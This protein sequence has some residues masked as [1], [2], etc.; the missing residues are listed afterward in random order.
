MSFYSPKD[1][2]PEFYEKQKNQNFVKTPKEM[3]F[4]IVGSGPA[5]FYMAKMLLTTIKNCRV[6]IFDRNPHPYGLIRTGVAPDHQAMKKI[7]KDFKQVFEH[8]ADRTAFFGNVWVGDVKEGQEDYEY[9][10]QHEHSISVHQL[11]TKYSGVILAH[12]ALKDR[13]LG[14]PKEES[15]GILPSRRVVNWYNDSLDNDLDIQNEF[16]LT[17]IRDLAVI[18]NGN[19]FCDIARQ[20]LKDPKD[21]A[22][23]DMPMSVIEILK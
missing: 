22:E 4:A 23:T 13:M 20:L 15:K 11:R 19:I 9:A 12:G 18:G 21:F 5:G 14:L 7:T 2:N 16:D 8:N 1:Y 17:K 6:D 10:S 3:R